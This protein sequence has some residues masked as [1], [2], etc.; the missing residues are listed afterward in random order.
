MLVKASTS[1][2]SKNSRS[3]SRCFVHTYITEKERDTESRTVGI[4]AW[5]FTRKKVA[6][7][8][9]ILFL[10]LLSLLSMACLAMNQEDRPHEVI[11]LCPQLDV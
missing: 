11:K 1:L 6:T 9:A 10:I 2:Y 5:Q 4:I 3:L 7:F 8:C